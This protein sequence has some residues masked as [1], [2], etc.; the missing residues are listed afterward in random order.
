MSIMRNG[1]VK[2]LDRSD[3]MGLARFVES[4]FYIAA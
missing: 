1:K 3:A 4:L 2:S